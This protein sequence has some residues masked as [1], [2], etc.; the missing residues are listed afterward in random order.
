MKGTQEQKKEQLVISIVSQ[1]LT[2]GSYE[3]R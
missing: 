3:V 1:F 2:N